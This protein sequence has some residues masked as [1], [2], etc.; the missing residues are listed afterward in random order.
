MVRMSIAIGLAI[1][2]FAACKDNAKP[3]PA[4]PTPVTAGTVGS[5]GVRRVAV[6][7]GLQGYQPERIGG[8]PGEKI[9]L[10]FTRTADSACIEQLKTPDGK[11]VD[12]PKGHPVE[13][14]VTVPQTGEVGFV[15]GM[16][17]IRGAVV[18]EKS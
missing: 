9:V 18:A 3:G 11:L 8:K 2:A 12:L 5:D 16:D 10:V 6:E 13:V 17:M 1:L 4:G 7:A 15:C 14:A